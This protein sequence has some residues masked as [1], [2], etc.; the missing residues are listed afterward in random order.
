MLCS[1]DWSKSI[2][3]MAASISRRAAIRSAAFGLLT[4][5]VPNIVF[6]KDIFAVAP[7]PPAEGLFYRYPAIDDAYVAEMVGVSHFNLDRVK[8]LIAMRPELARATWDWGFGDWESAIGAA[9]H[10]GRRDIVAFLMAHGARPTLFTYAMLGAFDVVKAAITATPGAQ[11]AGGPHG[12]SLLRHAK[13]GL[14]GKD[15]SAAQKAEGE[16]LVAYLIELGDADSKERWPDLSA[17]ERAKYL[18]DYRYGE[19]PEEGF[20]IKENM[21]ELLALGKIGKFGGALYEKSKGVYGY[22]GTTSVEITFQWEDERVVSLTVKEPDLELVAR[23][24]AE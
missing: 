11:Q 5:S 16:R 12:I 24:V 8:E 13:I 23:K 3:P 21:R 4:V 10:T 14:R 18:G 19:G 2:D 1:T 17:R 15:L 22:N 9:S 7:H 20:S 6:A